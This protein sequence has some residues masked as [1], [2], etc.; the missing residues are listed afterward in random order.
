MESA[1]EKLVGDIKVLLADVD[2]LFRQAAA[3][4]GEEARNLRE[5]AEDAL[6]E[7]RA[8]FETIQDDIVRRGR[9]AAHATDD[10]VHHNPWSS[11]GLGAGI[12][13]LLGFLIARR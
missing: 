10:W 1:R 7:A 8:R 9:D 13:L 4:S 2:T 11:I 6:K 12:G 3:S 5:R